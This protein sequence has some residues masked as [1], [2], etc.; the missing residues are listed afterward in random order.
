MI[1][2]KD[3]GDIDVLQP[4]DDR[5]IELVERKIAAGENVIIYTAW[6]RLDSQNK[7]FK[8]LNEK[9]IS[10]VILKP[11]VET[12]KREAWVE[13]KLQNGI[14]VL[15]TNPALVE[16]GRASARTPIAA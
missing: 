15:I 5:V 2:P 11:T 16:T 10:T 8:A 9:G 3:L 1:T 12:V 7:L 6:T 4:K 14:R 13:K